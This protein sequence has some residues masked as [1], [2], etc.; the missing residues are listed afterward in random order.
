VEKDHR[1][2][3]TKPNPGLMRLGDRLI[4]K[5]EDG[6]NQTQV[7]SETGGQGQVNGMPRS[8]RQESIRK[9]EFEQPSKMAKVVRG[10][11]WEEEGEPGSPTTT[12]ALVLSE[13]VGSSITTLNTKI[14]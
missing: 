6:T 1:V 14:H 2:N 8:K 9:G 7:E 3:D 5:R 4:K 11:G 12:D 13:I 10:E